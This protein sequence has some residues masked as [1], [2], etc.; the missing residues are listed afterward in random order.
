M[1][2][3]AAGLT[4]QNAAVAGTSA[5]VGNA[6][7]IAG[8]G[9]LVQA[10]DLLAETT[11]AGAASLSA[12]GASIGIAINDV[13]TSTTAQGRRGQSDH[14]LHGRRRVGGRRSRHEAIK[15]PPLPARIGLA[16]GLEA[17]VAVV[18]DSSAANANVENA[19][20]SAAR[21]GDRDGHAHARR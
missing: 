9:V 7:I 11:L 12:F 14:N 21:C 13:N 15:T 1:S 6:R 3:T 4:A 18:T 8:Q 20:V 5:T 19:N 10:N 17:A 16:G 2:A